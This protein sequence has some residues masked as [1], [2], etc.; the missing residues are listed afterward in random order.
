MSKVPFKLKKRF[1]GPI[2]SCRIGVKNR[3]WPVVCLLSKHSLNASWQRVVFTFS[4]SISRGL[5]HCPFKGIR[6][7]LL[8]L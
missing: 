3:T 7:R 5:C 8:L 1:Q 4:D 2:H 6:S